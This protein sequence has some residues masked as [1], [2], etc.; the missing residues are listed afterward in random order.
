[1][2]LTGKL[3]AEF[4]IKSSGDLFHDMFSNKPHHIS[5]ASPHHIQGCDLHD[6]EF[7][8]PGSVILWNYKID[9]KACVA[10]EIVEAID[11]ENKSITFKVIE[12]DLMN[13]YKIFKLTIDV[14]PKGDTSVVKWT[15]EYEKLHDGVDEALKILELAIRVTKDI[16]AHHLKA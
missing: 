6:G 3:I 9:G 16:E 5:K 15:L 12:G 8:T 1:M 14:T 2:G 11:V 10:K 4:E 13:D 7:G